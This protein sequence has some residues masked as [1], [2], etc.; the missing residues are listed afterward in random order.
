MIEVRALFFLVSRR[1]CISISVQQVRL[2][3]HQKVAD[4]LE[5]CQPQPTA[6]FNTPRFLCAALLASSIRVVHK[7]C[8]VLKC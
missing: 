4:I 3:V 6:E 1:L 2:T 8:S 5:A 7:A